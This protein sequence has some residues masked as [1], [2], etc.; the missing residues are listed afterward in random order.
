[1][2]QLRQNPDQP[3]ALFGHSR[4][5][6]AS[7]K[8]ARMLQKEG[9]RVDLLL[10]VD[11]VMIDLAASQRVPSNVKLAINYWENLSSPLGGLYL[12]GDP[13][14]SEIENRQVRAGHGTI[15]DLVAKAG[16]EFDEIMTR[17]SEMLRQAQEDKTRRGV[18][19]PRGRPCP[20]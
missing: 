19:D 5:A 12:T 18:C 13:E 15:D 14:S 9:I 10:T 1:M 2:S 6:A 16:A 17:V 3:V 8:L 7:L 11:P 4:G 20:N